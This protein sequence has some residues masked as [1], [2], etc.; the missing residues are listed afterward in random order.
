M[1]KILVSILSSGS[2]FGNSFMQLRIER[3][4][5]KFLKYFRLNMGKS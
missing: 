4:A 3:N 1:T 2:Q 5:L